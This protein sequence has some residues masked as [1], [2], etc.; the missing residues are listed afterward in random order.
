MSWHPAYTERVLAPDHRFAAAHLYP[1]FLDALTA[2]ARTVARLRSLT[3][4]RFV[5]HGDAE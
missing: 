2:H 4:G 5:Q 3:G 1:A